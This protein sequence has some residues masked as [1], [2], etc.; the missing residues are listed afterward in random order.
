[1]AWAR[2][3][4]PGPTPCLSALAVGAARPVGCDGSQHGYADRCETV[5]ADSTGPGG[6]EVDDPARD[7]GPPVVDPHDHGAAGLE[8]GDFH[9][10]AEGQGAV[11]RREPGGMGVFSV[12]RFFVAVDRCDTGLWLSQKWSGNSSRD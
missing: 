4:A 11:S 3:T 7:V 8:A 6:G 10:C 2:R 12:G 9:E 1:M 5:G